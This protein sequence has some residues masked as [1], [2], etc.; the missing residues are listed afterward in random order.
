MAM[1]HYTDDAGRRGI[2]RLGVITPSADGRVY[3]TPDS[4]DSG[5]VARR[6]LALRRTPTGYYEVPEA[7]LDRA[8]EPR[9]VN[10]DGGM[11]GGG[12]EV[13]VTHPIDVSGLRW[14]ELRP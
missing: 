12:T 6:R 7:R 13:H 2:E 5:E 9:R 8:S 1:R 14:M 10:G 11:S 4:Y 3:L